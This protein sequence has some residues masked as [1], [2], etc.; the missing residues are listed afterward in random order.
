[1]STKKYEILVFAL[2]L[3]VSN[4]FSQQKDSCKVL[5]IE[6]SGIY[7]GNCKNGLANGKGTA[8]G[9]DTYVG[10]FKNGFPDGKGKYTYKNGNV[11]SGYWSNGLKEG[12]GVFKYFVN[13][14]VFTQ[15]G[16][17]E[18]GEYVG[19]TNPDDLYRVTSSIGIE[20]Y[21]IKR[22]SDNENQIKISLVGAMTKYVPQDLKIETSSGLLKQDIKKFT[23]FQYKC[24]INCSIR[25]TFKT[26]GGSRQ[27]KLE[28]DI[29]K[30]GTYEVVISN[31]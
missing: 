10:M 30:P 8:K 12:N 17:W 6:I 23:I 29:L 19:A 7:Q 13:G 21:S 5:M 1:M 31:T 15:K 25:F 28:F 16:F 22:V 27:C 14:E 4:L 18:K 2:L 3:S 9:E 20:H 24:P 11:F 26:S